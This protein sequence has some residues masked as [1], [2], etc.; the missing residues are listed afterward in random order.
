MAL[1]W[2]FVSKITNSKHQ[3]TNKSQI[4]IRFK[5]IVFLFRIL[6]FDHCYLFEFWDLL[7]EISTKQIP[8]GPG[9][10]TSPPLRCAFTRYRLNTQGASCIQATT[11]TDGTQHSWPCA[12]GDYLGSQH[13]SFVIHILQPGTGHDGNH[14]FRAH[15]GLG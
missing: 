12:I 10:F 3:I 2:S 5:T 15:E 8:S 14:G 11:L 6:N 7:F 9:F 4:P 1:P 13:E